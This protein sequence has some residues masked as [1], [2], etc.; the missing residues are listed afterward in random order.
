MSDV[1]HVRYWADVLTGVSKFV[2]C[3]IDV[4]LRIVA[5][6][7]AADRVST[8]YVCYNSI[9]VH[10]RTFET[11]DRWWASRYFE[12]LGQRDVWPG[13]VKDHTGLGLTAKQIRSIALRV[14]HLYVAC[15]INLSIEET[16]Q[17]LPPILFSQ[18]LD[19]ASCMDSL[20]L[21]D[22]QDDD[23]SRPRGP[24]SDCRVNWVSVRPS[25]MV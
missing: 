16:L 7:V 9:N 21:E 4:Y 15:G 22:G 8:W 1:F 12:N 18:V 19:L 14:R 10:H 11:P 24:G 13:V 6:D 23:E 3:G 5:P 25:G 17:H 20:S 2:Y